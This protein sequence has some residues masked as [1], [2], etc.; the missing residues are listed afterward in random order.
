M[1][2]VA[3]FKL[4]GAEARA[5]QLAIAVAL[6]DLGARPRVIALLAGV[7]EKDARSIYTERNGKAASPGALPYSADAILKNDAQRLHAAML[8]GK[9]VQLKNLQLRHVDAFIKSYA[10]Y[11]VQF[12]RD[13]ISIDQFDHL[14][15]LFA[16]NNANLLRCESCESLMFVTKP[17]LCKCPVCKKLKAVGL[18]SK[19]RRAT[20]FISVQEFRGGKKAAA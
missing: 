3:E 5:E 4:Q 15:K 18:Q 6:A 1:P 9:Y 20:R 19:R 12:G 16:M 10:W 13:V 17:G 7:V 2:K 14:V 8:L 11:D